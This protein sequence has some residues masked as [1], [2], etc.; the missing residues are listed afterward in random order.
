MNKEQKFA[1]KLIDFIDASHSSF[2]ATKNVEEILIKEGFEKIELKDKWKLKKEGR[3]Y[4]T[5]NSSAII[6]FIIGKG[7][8][9][10]DGFRIVG[11]HT[12][13]PTFRIKPDPEITVAGKYLK[14]NTEVYGGPILSTWFDRPLS[15]AGR[16]SVKTQNPLKPKEVLIDMEKPIMIIPN[17]AIHMN[18]KVNEGIKIN[19]QID[20]LPLLSTINDK[21][22]KEN[23]IME[24]IAENIGIKT[25]DILDFELYLYSVEKGALI[26]LNEEFISI[27]RLDDLAMAHAGLYGLVDSK[28]GNATNILVCFD[29]EEVGSTTKQGAASPMLRSILERIAIAMG[30]DKEGY[31]RGL[32]NSFLISSDMAHSIHPNYMGK[33]DLTNRPVIN[34]GPVIKIAASQSY[35]S[36]SSSSAVYEGICKS[37]NVPVQKFVNRSDERGGSTIGPISSTQLDVPSVDIGNPILGMHSVRELGGV[38]DHYYAYK[39]FREFYSIIEI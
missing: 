35:T 5:K 10:D 4:V 8:I 25:E 13:S 36:D 39:S 1:E 9:E 6:G 17:L 12:D 28:I 38:F 34:G 22:E 19:P 26:G 11:A 18:R 30:K 31:Y 29:N 24:L 3:Y 37:I 21:F 14:L 15:M 32:S 2:H 33:Q 16:V 20:T 23:F 7:E 27:G